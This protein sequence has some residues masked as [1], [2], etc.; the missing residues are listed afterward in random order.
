MT[1]RELDELVPFDFVD[2]VEAHKMATKTQDVKDAYYA[3]II[4]NVQI[5]KGKHIKVQ[6]V[7]ETFHPVTRIDRKREEQRFIEEWTTAGGEI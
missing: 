3:C 4:T 2:L 7:V 6:D 5:A 1:P